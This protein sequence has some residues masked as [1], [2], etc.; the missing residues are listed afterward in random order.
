MVVVP[1]KTTQLR[2][3]V[4]KTFE[5]GKRS[6]FLVVANGNRGAADIV[7][8]IEIGPEN[9]V[10]TSLSQIELFNTEEEARQAYPQI[11]VSAP[12]SA[13]RT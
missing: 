12:I 3:T 4:V 8:L 7:H 5:R 10:G 6:G 13:I 1:D 11:P 9:E 2:G